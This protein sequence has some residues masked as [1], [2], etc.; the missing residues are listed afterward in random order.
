M[1][2]D[3]IHPDRGPDLG[4]GLVRDVRPCHGSKLTRGF[5]RLRSKTCLPSSPVQVVE[6]SGGGMAS[7]S[8]VHVGGVVSRTGNRLL[9]RRQLVFK[10]AIPAQSTGVSKQTSSSGVGLLGPYVL[11]FIPKPY[12]L[13]PVARNPKP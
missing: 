8:R 5:T 6:N 10:L 9:T 12:T 13:L 1:V 4:L 11:E 3:A 2:V 7:T